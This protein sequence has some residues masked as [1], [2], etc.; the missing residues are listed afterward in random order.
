MDDG[1]VA[2]VRA[3]VG[4]GPGIEERK[5]FRGIS[6]LVNG[7]IAVGVNPDGLLVRLGEVGQDAALARPH[8]SPFA[9][10]GKAKRGWV[11]VAPVGLEDEADFR[12][13]VETGLAAARALPAK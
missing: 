13:R 4:T 2:R 12:S 8:A 1:L 10:A 11:M 6:F 3:A 7:N 5:M 9:I